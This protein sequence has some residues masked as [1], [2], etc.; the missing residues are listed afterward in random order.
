MSS[1]GGSKEGRWTM[2]STTK[3]EHDWF[4]LYGGI[5][6]IYRVKDLSLNTI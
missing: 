1:T 6:F 2:S 3:K 5:N 4:E